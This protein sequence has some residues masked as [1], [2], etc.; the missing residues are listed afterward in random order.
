M[1]KCG[2]PVVIRIVFWTIAFDFKFVHTLEPLFD[3][4]ITCRMGI[5]Q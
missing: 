4:R 5:I 2:F 1:V 3:L